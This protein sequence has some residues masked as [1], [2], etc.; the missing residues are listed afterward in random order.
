VRPIVKLE[1]RTVVLGALRQAEDEAVLSFVA[2]TFDRYV[3][4]LQNLAGTLQEGVRCGRWGFDRFCVMLC[5]AVLTQMMV[6][7]GHGRE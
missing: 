7:V 4:T 2:E 6:I 5:K 1:G 3:L